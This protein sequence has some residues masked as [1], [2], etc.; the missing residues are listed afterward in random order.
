MA[1]HLRFPPF[2]FPS[3]LICCDG[4]SNAYHSKCLEIRPES[5]PDPWHCPRC[6]NKGG[7]KTFKEEESADT[8]DSNRKVESL[9]DRPNAH[10]PVV[11]CEDSAK[12]NLLGQCPLLQVSHLF[13]S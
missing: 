3:V 8:D 13:V 11:D 6:C 7:W 10:A 5:L 2:I 4:C 12:S 9:F 1:P